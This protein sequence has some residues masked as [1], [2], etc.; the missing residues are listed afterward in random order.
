MNLDSEKY[1]AQGLVDLSTVLSDVAPARQALWPW[2]TDCTVITIKNGR[3][4][5]DAV[6]H[7]SLNIEPVFYP[8]E[9]TCGLRV[10]IKNNLSQPLVILR[11]NDSATVF[12]QVEI[13]ALPGVSL[14]L[15]ELF[16]DEGA[17]R[18][19]S[20]ST[21]ITMQKNASLRWHRLDKTKP[22][23]KYVHKS[24]IT[25]MAGSF[26]RLMDIGFNLGDF[27]LHTNV[28]LAENNAACDFFGFELL[29]QSAR[30][31]SLLQIFHQGQATKSAQVFR[32]IYCQKSVGDFLGKVIV[33]TSGK[34]SQV[35]QL[36]KS[37]LIGN[38]A[39]ACAKPQLEIN[40]HD[41]TA[42]HGATIGSFDDNALF[43]LRARGLSLKEAE[44]LLVR[45][46]AS[47]VFSHI[48][49]SGLKESVEA[50]LQ[51]ALAPSGVYQ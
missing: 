20:S 51:A 41:I 37:I 3:H 5:P 8:E 28:Y 25:Q 32:G 4:L 10:E 11:L 23:S 6:G 36:Y 21:N 16:V 46:L 44:S 43:Y 45:A 42:S 29:N 19:A 31:L 47:Q 49:I 50:M 27:S 12:S 33:E 13:L 7:P 15:I 26:S 38:E 48:E 30:R 1:C 35:R 24:T 34:Y 17:G 40:N 18:C 14:D 2:L 39:K 9:G 22:G